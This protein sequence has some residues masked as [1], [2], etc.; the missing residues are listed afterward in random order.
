MAAV[1]LFLPVAY[2]LALMYLKYSKD[3]IDG[4][5]E[6]EFLGIKF[7]NGTD[8]ENHLIH[9]GKDFVLVLYDLAW[10]ILNPNDATKDYGTDIICSFAGILYYAY[11]VV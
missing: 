8:T 1:Y 9:F 5:H 4:T 10:K 2:T 11:Q 7:R 3:R 6:S